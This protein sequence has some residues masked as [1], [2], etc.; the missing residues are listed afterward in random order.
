MTLGAIILRAR[1]L[2]DDII[3]PYLWQD[4]EIISYVNDCIIEMCS[5]AATITD[6]Q[7]DAICKINVLDNVANYLLDERV[8]SVLS[9]SI[10]GSS[11]PLIK[12]SAAF[13][14]SCCPAWQDLYG[15]PVNYLTDALSGFITLWPKPIKTD[16][17]TLTVTRLPMKQLTKENINEEPEISF[18]Y[19][20]KLLDGV[21][22]KAY[23]KMDADT[24]N[25]ELSKSHEE[26]WNKTLQD[27]KLQQIRDR[28]TETTAGPV[29][30]AI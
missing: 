26:R 3:E 16:T 8:I 12:T 22:Y 19:H 14:R 13:L 11:L 10:E 2:L 30:G 29:M 17:L 9:A 28:Y 15:A 5:D 6:S 18:K 24:Y 20:H 25:P 23:E 21:L 27:I 4:D 7:T 1:R